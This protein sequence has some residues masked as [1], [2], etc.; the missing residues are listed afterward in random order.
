MHA[1]SPAVCALK[2]SSREKQAE[3]FHFVWERKSYKKLWSELVMSRCRW[4]FLGE[5]Q[6]NSGYWHSV[7][8][9][10]QLQINYWSWKSCSFHKTFDI[11]AWGSKFGH[12]PHQHAQQVE[13]GFK[14]SSGESD[15]DR[16]IHGV[17]CPVSRTYW[18]ASSQGETLS[19][20]RWKV[21]LRW[22]SNILPDVY[23][24]VCTHTHTYTQYAHIQTCKHIRFFSL[25]LSFIIDLT[26]RPVRSTLIGIFSC[27]TSRIHS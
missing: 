3:S 11:Q 6:I 1:Y 9:I 22:H 8:T 23:T 20:R 19:Q 13:Q 18:W 21:F 27:L 12:H 26:T 25:S 14:P 10:L 5:H 17:H 2:T 15:R 16:G 4:R 24:R 7:S